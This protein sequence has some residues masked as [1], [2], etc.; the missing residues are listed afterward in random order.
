MSKDEFLQRREAYR[1]V[2]G[3]PEGEEVLAD[4]LNICGYFDRVFEDPSGMV[5]M[6]VARE[7]LFRSGVTDHTDPDRMIDV[8][9]SLLAIDPANPYR[10]DEERE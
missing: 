5:R 9:R 3:T 6:D 1:T 7:I 4:I 8:T 2:F 10:D